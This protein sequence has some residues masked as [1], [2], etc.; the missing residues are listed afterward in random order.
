MS[1]KTSP[2]KSK[3]PNKDQI[4]QVLLAERSKLLAAAWGMLGDFH[5]AEDVFQDSL[6][7]A[8]HHEGNFDS[9][10]HLRAWSWRVARNRAREL[11]RKKKPGAIFL[12]D[13]LLELIAEEVR[14]RDT[15]AIGRMGDALADCLSRLTAN[16]QELIQLRYVKGMRAVDVARRLGRKANSVHVS[17]SRIYRTLAECIEQ[18]L[19]DEEAT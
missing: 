12:D 8:L 9:V 7:R 19:S 11:L 3:G 18:R 10:D 4:V 14:Q 15:G 2:K 16:A 13:A 1:Q 5:A 6:V 17:L